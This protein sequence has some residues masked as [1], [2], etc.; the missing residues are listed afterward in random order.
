MGRRYQRRGRGRVV[1]GRGRGDGGLAR[2]ALRG[3]GGCCLGPGLRCL[4]GSLAGVTVGLLRGHALLDGSLV[5]LRQPERQAKPRAVAQVAPRL[6][7]RAQVSGAS[8]PLAG[9]VVAGLQRGL[10]GADGKDV[11]H[12]VDQREVTWHARLVVEEHGGA[13]GGRGEVPVGPRDQLLL[14]HVGHDHP[15]RVLPTGGEPRPDGGLLA[16]AGVGVAGAVRGPLQ[17][18]RVH[19]RAG[20]LGLPF[21]GGAAGRGSPRTGP[22]AAAAGVGAV[23]R[24]ELVEDERPGAGPPGHGH[25]TD[26]D[27][28]AGRA[29]AARRE[30]VGALDGRATT[31]G[32]VGFGRGGER[33]HTCLGLCR[34]LR[35]TCGPST[36]PASL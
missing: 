28:T 15:P 2:L 3:G 30:V 1:G 36:V 12:G 31:G 26:G 6:L 11:H 21:L 7:E 13:A 27:A 18:V 25:A 33:R 14:A 9:G 17:D 20:P 34:W 8:G 10:R 35:L 19:G 22:D 32:P 5:A 23:G 4:L 16:L 29:H 24:L